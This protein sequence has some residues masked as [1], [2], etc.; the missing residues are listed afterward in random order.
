VDLGVDE[1]DVQRFGKACHGTSA[2]IQTRVRGPES[3]FERNGERAALADR[4][5][6]RR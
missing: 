3:E 6:P 2:S 1:D 4:M 5:P